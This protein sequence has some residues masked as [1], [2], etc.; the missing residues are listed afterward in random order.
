MWKFNYYKQKFTYFT[1]Y[2]TTLKQKQPVIK[3]I[4]AT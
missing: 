2:A 4:Y 1:Q 3:D